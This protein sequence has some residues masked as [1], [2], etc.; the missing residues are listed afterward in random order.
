MSP[1]VIPKDRAGRE[2]LQ[3][4]ADFVY[5]RAR[6]DKA[7]ENLRVA[8][9]ERTPYGLDS[10]HS[11]LLDRAMTVAH[12]G[13][14]PD[15]VDRLNRERAASEKRAVPS[16]T[17]PWA[18]AA[19]PPFVNEAVSY[20]VRA[21]APL[22]AALERL[23]LPPSGTVVSWAKVTTGA[24]VTNQ[25]AENTAMTASADPVVASATDA[26][27]TLGAYV[28]F[29]A[30]AQELSGGW[31]DRVIGEELGRAFG[32]RLETQLWNG[33]GANGQLKGFAVMTGGSSST[34]SGQT[35]PLTV[36]KISD[37]FHQV[38]SNLGEQPDLLVVAPRR[39]AALEAA[40]GALGLE[41]SGLIPQ[42]MQLV[43]SPA[44]PT[45]LGASEDW[46]LLINKAAVPL[47][48]DPSPTV[49]FHREGPSAGTTLL[50]RWLIYQFA[51]LGVSRRPEGV[52]IVKGLT[53]PTFT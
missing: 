1:R 41:M 43:I 45:N 4:E 31:F 10:P 49:E 27:G 15:A 50:F 14:V 11:W 47:V 6:A 28:D 20:G 37:Q 8:V 12:A 9:A 3:I 17:F 36:N 48:R 42:G 44:A 26:L 16:T 29:S 24:T 51:A 13:A 40:T 33:T 38:T 5:A 39:Y 30:Q 53:A 19:V 23:D 25:T 21:S 35:L 32:T 52:G 22:A 7:R 46:I 18:A 34:V 2:R